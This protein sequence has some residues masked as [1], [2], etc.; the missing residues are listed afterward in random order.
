VFLWDVASKKVRLTLKAPASVSN[1]IWSPNGKVLISGGSD[2][3]V[4]DPATGKLIRSFPVGDATDSAFGLAITKDGKLL[5][6]ASHRGNIQIWDVATG[7]ARLTLK[8]PPSKAAPTVKPLGELGKE[9]AGNVYCVAISPDD[10]LLAAGV[11]RTV[12]IWDIKA[13][14]NTD[15]TEKPPK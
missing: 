3:R 12:R 15:A 10:T 4:W 8:K 9:L 7:E 14:L 1:V 2:I 13:L 6:S 5:A 11:G